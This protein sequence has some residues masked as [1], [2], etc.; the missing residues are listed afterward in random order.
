MT[1]CSKCGVRLTDER[2]LECADEDTEFSGGA[3]YTACLERQLANL[4]SLLRSVTEKLEAAA[5]LNEANELEAS[6]S[7]IQKALEMLA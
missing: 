2:Y 4:R 6:L 5:E 3:A 1:T 7:Y